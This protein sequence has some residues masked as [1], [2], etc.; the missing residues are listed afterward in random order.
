MEGSS[1]QVGYT[2]GVGVFVSMIV[3][4]DVRACKQLLELALPCPLVL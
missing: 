1:K 4:G 3:P 2:G